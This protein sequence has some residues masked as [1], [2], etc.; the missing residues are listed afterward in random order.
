MFLSKLIK[1]AIADA[2]WYFADPVC[3]DIGQAFICYSP[4]GKRNRF[5]VHSGSLKNDWRILEH[6]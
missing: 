5:T 2:E 4:F 6:S 3:S 1:D